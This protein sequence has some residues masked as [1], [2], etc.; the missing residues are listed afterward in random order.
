MKTPLL[1]ELGTDGFSLALFVTKVSDSKIESVDDIVRQCDACMDNVFGKIDRLTA[2]IHLTDSCNLRCSY[3]F[4]PH[5]PKSLSIG[6]GKKIIDSLVRTA[7]DNGI[8]KLKLKYAGGEPLQNFNTL[9]ALHQ[10]AIDSDI[11]IIA[12]LLTNG[13]MLN[14]EVLEWIKNSGVQLV[15]SLDSISGSQRVYKNGEES[16]TLVMK[17][18]ESAIANGV[19]PS[20]TI[21]IQS[22]T[23]D[24]LPELLEW[25]LE[26]ELQFSI[27]FYKGKEPIDTQKIIDGMLKAFKIIEKNPPKQSLLNSLLDM[28]NLAEPHLRSCSVGQNYIIFDTDG[29]I[30]QCPMTMNQPVSDVN[31]DSILADIQN[32]SNSL[33]NPS[34]D[35]IDECK[36]CQW[37]YWCG[38]GCA[39]VNSFCSGK[40]PYCEVYKR[41]FPEV[42][43]LGN[44]IKSF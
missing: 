24:G 4:L 32:S 34:V 23:V 13:T 44:P 20:I 1:D 28:T 8:K 31:S 2:W 5:E 7:K 36:E 25:I 12:S 11:E 6:M 26:K 14:Q 33:K 9:K 22:E 40:S 43:R 29:N 15:I 37:R 35:E 19:K 39:V 27:N 38:G 16:S 3:C 42:L 10:Y 21:T 17:N 18:I 30:S 41:L